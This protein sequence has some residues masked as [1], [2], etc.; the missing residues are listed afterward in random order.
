M[1]ESA[2][3][4]PSWQGLHVASGLA[5]LLCLPVFCRLLHTWHVLMCDWV[6]LHGL[7]ESSSTVIERKQDCV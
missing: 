1:E 4:C 2:H 6:M 7:D 3:L 5:V